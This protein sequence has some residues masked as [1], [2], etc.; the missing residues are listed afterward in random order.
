MVQCLDE[1]ERGYSV[2]SLRCSGHAYLTPVD[3]LGAPAARLFVT[4]LSSSAWFS[5]HCA[6]AS[7]DAANGR[8]AVR[9]SRKKSAP[10]SGKAVF[11][12][13][14]AINLEGKTANTS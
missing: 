10:P 1:F 11:V 5:F 12:K 4:S 13:A 9:L 2:E 6:I 3:P 14:K 7:F 8:Y